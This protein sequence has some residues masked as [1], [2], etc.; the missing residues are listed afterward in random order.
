MDKQRRELAWEML[1][2]TYERL[3]ERVARKA[4]DTG[5]MAD[6]LAVVDQVNAECD[7]EPVSD[8]LIE[9]L[10][11]DLDD[12]YD[13]FRLRAFLYA[14]ALWE[15]GGW[16]QLIG[17]LRRAFNP[18]ASRQQGPREVAH[19]PARRRPRRRTRHPPPG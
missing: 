4:F 18:G 5:R 16:V 9:R 13:R 11:Q 7:V 12:P 1:G 19:Q 3:V 17:R 2:L 15:V 14:S 6:F 8:A 10:S